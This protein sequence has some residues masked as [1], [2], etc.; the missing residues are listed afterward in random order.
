MP[1]AARGSNYTAAVEA[2]KAGLDLFPQDEELWVRY[3]QGLEG[4]GDYK[5]AG[6]AYR[7]AINLDPNLGIIRSHYSGHLRRVG[8]EAEAEE[9]KAFASQASQV[10]LAPIPAFRQLA[11]PEEEQDAARIQ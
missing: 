11:A 3:A 4:L 8:R 1:R 2:F 5:A 9:Q 10:N 6:E 7:E